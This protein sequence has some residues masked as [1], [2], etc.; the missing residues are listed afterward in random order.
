M[1]EIQGDL[2][3]WRAHLKCGVIITTNGMVKAS[4]K[5]VMGRG[6]ALEAKKRFP[7]LDRLLGRFVLL[8]GNKPFRFLYQEAQLMTFPT[9][10]LWREVSNKD[11]IV[12]SAERIRLL[13]GQE[14]M[15]YISGRP[16]CGNGELDWEEVKPLLIPILPDN[17][18]ITSW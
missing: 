11:L 9:K 17:V 7:G 6:I 18:L 1:I 4:G 16:G 15:I 13:L 3:E 5:L 12:E 14:R 10:Y 2:W 8:N